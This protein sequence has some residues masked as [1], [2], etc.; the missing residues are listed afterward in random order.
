MA[1]KFLVL[2]QYQKF[3]IMVKKAIKKVR[4]ICPLT[5]PFIYCRERQ[6]LNKRGRDPFVYDK[7]N[8][9]VYL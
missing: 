8:V 3:C 7:G 1:K 4:D 6:S 9:I 2:I 5:K